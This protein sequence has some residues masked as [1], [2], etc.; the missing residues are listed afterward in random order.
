MSMF[1][2]GTNSKTAVKWGV[3]TVAAVLALIVVFSSFTTVPA[4][5]TGVITQFGAVSSNVLSEG[6]HLKIPF[7][8]TVHMV[9]NQVLKVDVDA[10]SASKDLQTLKSTISINYRVDQNS[11]ASLYKNVGLDY[12]DVIIR[13]AINECVKAVTAQYTAEELITKRQDV[14]EQ[15][16]SLVSD[17]IDVY[18][19]RV[20]IFN[21]INFDFSD[22]FNKAIEAKQTA[23]QNALK[24]E[25]DLAKVK[26][27][28][29]QKV[30]Q[31]KAEAEATRTKADADAYAIDKIQQQLAKDPNY[32]QYILATTW[33][34]K[35]PLV[36]GESGAILDLGR[37]MD[38]TA[39]SPS[40]TP[41]AAPPVTPES[42]QP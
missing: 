1:N 5:H 13:P 19:L 24:A 7:I 28:A 10:S 15:M 17:K 16:R 40:V 41:S 33:D 38:T 31:A 14:G 9:N 2:K 29:Q 25:Q 20:E 11:S 21:I 26:V 42:S 34:G 12:E 32:I 3:I 36:M 23:Q 22:E 35:Q 39:V 6:L 37:L 27:D 18:G 8:Q 4:G 30:E